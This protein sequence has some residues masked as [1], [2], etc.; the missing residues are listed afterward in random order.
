MKQIT[1]GNCVVYFEPFEDMTFVHLDVHGRFSF[2]DFRW[3][4]SVLPDLGEIYAPVDTGDEKLIKLLTDL[5]FEKT[6]IGVYG[7][8]G[9]IRRAY[10][11][12]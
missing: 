8:D 2:K 5:G 10:K 1:N 9:Y 7:T 6:D 11:W 12:Q 3:M 4:M